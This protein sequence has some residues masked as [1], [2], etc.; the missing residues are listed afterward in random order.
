MKKNMG[1]VDRAVRVVLGLAL[2]VCGAVLLAGAWQIVAIVIGAIFLLT[3]ILGFCP[4]YLP[5]GVS[6]K[7]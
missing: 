2:V 7:R 5:F 3:A 4:L 1:I 6:T